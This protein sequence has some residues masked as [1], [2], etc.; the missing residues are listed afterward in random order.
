MDKEI[1][2]K[3]QELKNLKIEQENLLQKIEQYDCSQ[4]LKQPV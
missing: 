2:R 3:Q 1:R 4:E